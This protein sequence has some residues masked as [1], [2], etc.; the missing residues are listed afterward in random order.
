[1]L[2]HTAAFALLIAALP[3][4]AAAAARCPPARVPPSP[5]YLDLVTRYASGDHGA[6]V[7]VLGNWDRDRLSCDL[8]NLQAAA[9]AVRRCPKVCEDRVV[10]EQFSIRAAILLHADR[11]IWEQFGPP[12]SEQ[13][14]SCGTGRQAQ[15][16]ERLAAMLLLVDPQA[17][18]FLRRFYL[19]MARRAHWSHCLREAEQWAR[20]G[21][22]RLPKDG[23]LLLTVGTVLD[24]TASLTLAPAPRTATLGPEALRQFEAQTNKRNVLWVSVRRALEDAVAA[25][26]DLHEARLRLGRVLWRLDRPDQARALLGEVLS[27]SDDPDLVY[28]AHLFLGRI[29]EDAGRFAEAEKEYQAALTLRPF[30]EPAAVAASHARLLLGDAEGAREALGSALDP[31]RRRPDVDPYKRYLMAHTHEGRMILDE[32]REEVV[33]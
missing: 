16:V 29:H 32:L 33:R 31:S 9:V 23:A 13:E 2:V 28:L 10:F 15:V 1:L 8:D 11:E 24:T 25:D 26:P 6:A 3:S 4:P 27:G 20:A 5:E 30:S 19:G 18:V 21:L 12:V 22:K 14:A 17:K 7:D